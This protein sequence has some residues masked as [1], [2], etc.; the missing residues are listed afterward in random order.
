MSVS[1]TSSNWDAAN[2]GVKQF[3]V[4]LLMNRSENFVLT[5]P[6]CKPTTTLCLFF[7]FSSREAGLINILS[8]DF[9]IR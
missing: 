6:G 7:L 8:A 2:S 4:L 3:F 1:N 9:A 5:V